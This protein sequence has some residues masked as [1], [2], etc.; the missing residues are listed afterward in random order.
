MYFAEE[1]I[2]NDRTKEFIEN[3][4]PQLKTIL[5]CTYLI[6]KNQ[7]DDDIITGDVYNCYLELQSQLPGL[8]KLTQRRVSEL[9]RELDLAGIINAR[10]VSKGRY[11]RSKMIRLNIPL[12]ETK[13]Y[14]ESDKKLEDFM[15]Y[16]PVCLHDPT[17]SR[18]Q[19][20]NYQR[21]G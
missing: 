12:E 2:E 19:N 10:V 18:F 9:L 21:L 20:F 15:E 13:K 5:M 1:D 4:P 11:G 16:R 3:L 7:Y 6:Q 17:M 14:L 8:N